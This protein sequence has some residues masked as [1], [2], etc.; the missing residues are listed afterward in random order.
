[1]KTDNPVTERTN[2]V[3]YTE[4]ACDI[5]E[6]AALISALDQVVTVC[7]T[8]V[9]Y[10]GALGKPVWVMAPM[11]PEW[12]YGLRSERMPWYP[13]SRM[14]RQTT[15]GDWDGLVTRV[16]QDLTAVCQPQ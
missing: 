16:R 11:V 10:A 1:M 3:W 12:R 7:N 6:F 15:I 5:D 4:A 2:R 9:H 14:Y 13:S 8:T